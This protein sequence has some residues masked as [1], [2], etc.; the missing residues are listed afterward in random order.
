MIMLDFEKAYDRIEW[1]FVLGMLKTFGFPPF[2][3]SWISII[4]K[5]SSI[6]ID[7]NG[8]ITNPIVL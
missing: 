8:E 4:L 6:V 1:S 3:C 2:F 5:D 7:V